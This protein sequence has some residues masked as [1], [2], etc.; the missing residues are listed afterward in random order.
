MELHSSDICSDHIPYSNPIL[1]H[2]MSETIKTDSDF[3]EGTEVFVYHNNE[4]G[5]W[6]YSVCPKSDPTYWIWSF[7]TLDEAKK[8]IKELKYKLVD[9]LRTMS[10]FT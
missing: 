1:S 4:T 3:D 6:L 10:D 5:E 2:I 8:F 7:E 9:N